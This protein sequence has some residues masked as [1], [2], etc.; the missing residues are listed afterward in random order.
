M[1]ELLFVI[2]FF[3][4]LLVT[5]VSLLGIIAAIVVA[6]AL[7]FVGGLFALLIKLL[8][9]LLLA[10]VVVWVIRALKTPDGNAFRDNNRWR[11]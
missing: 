6:T 4:M 9:W 5:G 2:G 8:P 3:V 11:Y 1:L 7:M 10:V